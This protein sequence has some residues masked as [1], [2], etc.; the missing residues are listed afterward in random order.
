MRII[1][2]RFR[3]MRLPSPKGSKVRPTVDRVREALFSTLGVMVEGA[4]VLDLFAGTGAFGFEALSRGAASVVFVE[5]DRQA[6]TV[7]AAT[8]RGFGIGNEVQVL[9]MS[10]LDA[11][12][13]L[14]KLEARFTIIFL[15]PP[16][17]SEWI[18]K[19][20]ADPIFPNLL[21]PEG[22]FIVEKGVHTSEPPPPPVFGKRFSRKYGGT[23][24][25]IFHKV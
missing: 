22:M 14:D 6:G 5:K 23:V 2:G 19:V 13:R 21:E 4:R 17:E 3:G 11:L 15:D 24:V 16:Y 25:E 18:T 8:A 1:S 20:L 9:N 12:R 7:I 10:A